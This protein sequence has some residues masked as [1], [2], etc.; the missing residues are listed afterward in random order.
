MPRSKSKRTKRN[1][2]TLLPDEMIDGPLEKRLDAQ[3]KAWK[4]ELKRTTVIPDKNP[5]KRA[6][7]AL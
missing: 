5:E 4:R 2:I 1:L 6:K 3:V 7:K